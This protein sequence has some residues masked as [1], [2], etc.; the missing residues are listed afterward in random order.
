MSDRKLGDALVKL[1]PGA[2]QADDAQQMSRLVAADRRRIRIWTAITILVW[3]PAVLTILGV[4][5]YLGLLFPLQAKLNQIRDAQKAAPPA[6][7]QNPD[8]HEHAGRVL[9]LAQ[10]ERDA[11]IGFQMM[12]VLTALA[13]LSLAAALLSSFALTFVTRRAT[14]RQINASLLAISDQ[15]K[16]LETAA[17]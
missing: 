16:R 12:T 8:R 11:E 3:L 4:L 13:V 15:L 17:R 1:D 14:L 2:P 9:N 10:L 6:A 5:V 7:G